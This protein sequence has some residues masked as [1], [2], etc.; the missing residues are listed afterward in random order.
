MHKTMPHLNDEHMQLYEWTGAEPNRLQH[1]RQIQAR[2]PLACFLR[3]AAVLTS[4]LS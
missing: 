2:P 4:L 1:A 3:R